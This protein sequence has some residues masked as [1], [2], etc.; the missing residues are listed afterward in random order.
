MLGKGHVR[1]T[2]LDESLATSAKLTG[3]PDFTASSAT[4]MRNGV[5]PL[6]E[7]SPLAK[8]LLSLPLCTWVAVRSSL[9]AL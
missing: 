9:Q 5:S 6:Q 2:P 8:S 4:A 7:S 3:S 1:V